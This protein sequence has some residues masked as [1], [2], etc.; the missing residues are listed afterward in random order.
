MK[1]NKKKEN[2]AMFSG[3]LPVDDDDDLATTCEK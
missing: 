2:K 1:E 3:E